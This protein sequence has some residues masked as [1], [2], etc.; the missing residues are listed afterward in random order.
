MECP[1]SREAGARRAQKR[2]LM[3]QIAVGGCGGDPRQAWP[4]SK[5]TPKFT[6]A[7]KSDGERCARRT[8]AIPHKTKNRASK[9]SSL[10]FF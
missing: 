7:S 10:F 6:G 8:A 1:V 5:S 9:P 4:Q 2:T 3:V